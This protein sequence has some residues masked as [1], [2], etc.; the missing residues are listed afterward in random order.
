M[1]HRSLRVLWTQ[2]QTVLLD[3]LSACR[4]TCCDIGGRCAPINGE[5]YN[6]LHRLTEAIDDLAV[7]LTGD[8]S[9]FWQSRHSTPDATRRRED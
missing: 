2:D 3:A 6:A 5:L 9:Y 7:I 1:A 4:R 8:R